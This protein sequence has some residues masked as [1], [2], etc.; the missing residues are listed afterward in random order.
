MCPGPEEEVD[1][2]TP[3]L[4]PR[5]RRERSLR[6]CVLVRI[7]SCWLLQ[8]GRLRIRAEGLPTSRAARRPARRG[9]RRRQGSLCSRHRPHD[10]RQLPLRMLAAAARRGLAVPAGPAGGFPR[11]VRGCHTQLRD[12]DTKLSTLWERW[13]GRVRAPPAGGGKGR[14]RVPLPAVCGDPRHI[15][16][17]FIGAIL[18]SPRTL[19]P[20]SDQTFA[21]R[22][23]PCPG[24]ANVGSRDAPWS[25][26]LAA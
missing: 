5:V 22:L 4:H 7:G 12:P 17:A 19:R 6:L 1:R 8:A 21:T 9:E 14:G 3:P 25:V 15:A 16:A 20:E 18:R 26:A 23:C 2:G 13:D 24:L 10:R 11:K